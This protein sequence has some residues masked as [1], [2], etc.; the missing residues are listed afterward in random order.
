[1]SQLSPNLINTVIEHYGLEIDIL[2]VDTVMTAWFEK[3][4]PIWIVKAII[5]SLYRGRYKV[6]SVDNIL[7]DWQ[8]MGKPRCNFTPDYEREILQKLPTL[9]DL[10]VTPAPSTAGI[11]PKLPINCPPV[12]DSKDL[13]PEESP[14]FQHHLQQ[15]SPFNTFSPAVE[16]G[17]RS[18][19]TQL[20]QPEEIDSRFETLHERFDAENIE[21]ST[22]PPRAYAATSDRQHTVKTGTIASVPVKLHLFNTLKA[23]V[24]QNHQQVRGFQ[25]PPLLQLTAA[26][27][28]DRFHS[29]PTQGIL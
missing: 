1:M 27:K 20:A 4:D 8:R 17:D 28:I 13:N 2:P 18:K 29:E 25:S 22:S 3:Y 19:V 6:K 16:E 10:N 26:D 23:I 9:V 21:L 5:E 12:I 11:E 15:I 14:A 24:E 7:K